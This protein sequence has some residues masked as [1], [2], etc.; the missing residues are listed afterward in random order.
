M[1]IGSGSSSEN[2]RGGERERETDGLNPPLCGRAP[3][4]RTVIPGPKPELD[5][6][7]SYRSVRLDSSSFQYWRNGSC[8]KGKGVYRRGKY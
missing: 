3:P 2:E 7:P 8:E 4:H 1:E 5:F 6:F